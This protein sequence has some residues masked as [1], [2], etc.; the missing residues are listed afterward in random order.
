MYTLAV[1]TVEQFGDGDDLQRVIPTIEQEI[2]AFPSSLYLG[3]H[4]L[5]RQAGADQETEL[6]FFTQPVAV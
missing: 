2:L 5:G 3:E 6:G 4:C 1:G